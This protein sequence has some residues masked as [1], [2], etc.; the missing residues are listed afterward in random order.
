[1]AE[2]RE[3]IA[4]MQNLALLLMQ[5]QTLFP[6]MT[7]NSKPTL[8]AGKH[9]HVYY[10]SHQ[11][12]GTKLVLSPLGIAQETPVKHPLLVFLAVKVSTIIG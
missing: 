10:R 6:I 4:A 2:N 11:L 8:Y 5:G 1:M 9:L 12:P 3:E 7:G